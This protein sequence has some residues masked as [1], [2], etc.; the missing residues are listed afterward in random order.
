MG[1]AQ[2]DIG[3]KAKSAL[4]ELAAVTYLRRALS[5]GWLPIFCAFHL[6]RIVDS[7]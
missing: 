7:T 6:L 1:L 2:C 5:V 3:S 4:P